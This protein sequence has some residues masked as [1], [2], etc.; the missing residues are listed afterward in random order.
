MGSPKT[1]KG[2]RRGGKSRSRSKSGRRNI[3][4]KTSWVPLRLLRGRGVVVVAEEVE[5]EQGI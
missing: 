2:E 3:I 5:V 4:W 1:I